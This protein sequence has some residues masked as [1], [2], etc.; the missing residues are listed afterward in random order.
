MGVVLYFCVGV[1]VHSPLYDMSRLSNMI[2]YYFCCFNVAICFYTGGWLQFLPIMHAKSVKSYQY[3]LRLLYMMFLTTKRVRAVNLMS[4]SR[5][6][7]KRV[8]YPVE[9]LWPVQLTEVYQCIRLLTQVPTAPV[10]PSYARYGIFISWYKFSA[11]H[12][13]WWGGKCTAWYC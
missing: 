11:V 3:E 4:L 1:S 8:L 7:T 2:M 5:F 6:R 10:T 13:V 12:N 9:A